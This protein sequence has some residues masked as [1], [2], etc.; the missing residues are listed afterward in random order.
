MTLELLPAVDLLDGIVDNWV[1][2]AS[3]YAIARGTRPETARAEARLSVA[4]MRG[5][6]LDL[7][8]LR[9]GIPLTR[10]LVAA[11]QH[12]GVQVVVEGVE[13]DNQRAVGEQRIQ[14]ITPHGDQRVDVRNL[15]F[16]Q[17]CDQIGSPVATFARR[18]RR[19]LLELVHEDEDAAQPARSASAQPGAEVAGLGAQ[20]LDHRAEPRTEQGAGRAAV[21]RRRGD[22][23]GMSSENVRCAVRVREVIDHGGQRGQGLAPSGSSGGSG[24]GGWGKAQLWPIWG[25]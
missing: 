25:P 18:E 13:D 10:A 17:A 7:A 11:A 22:I 20:A 8:E 15:R 4:V 24:G 6:L 5:L 12:L 9:D 3:Q 23:D 14:Q 19:E 16:C 1:E 21:E 2:P